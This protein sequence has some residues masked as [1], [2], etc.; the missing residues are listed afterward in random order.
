MLQCERVVVGS[1]TSAMSTI[2]QLAVG[3]PTH[4]EKLRPGILFHLEVEEEKA[5]TLFRYWR[6][7]PGQ[8]CARK[9][10]PLVTNPPSILP[11]TYPPA[12]LR[13]VIN[14]PAKSQTNIRW[15][16]K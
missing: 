6:Q 7:A 2:N 15:R 12:W 14:S 11:T 4:G 9:V 3:P 1:A 16:P 8:S 10:T 13:T 5:P